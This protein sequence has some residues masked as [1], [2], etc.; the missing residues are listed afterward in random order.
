MLELFS[1]RIIAIVIVI[2]ISIFVII[3]VIAAFI[4]VIFTVYLSCAYGHFSCVTPLILKTTPCFYRKKLRHD[5]AKWMLRLS[6]P[7]SV[8]MGLGP[9]VSDIFWSH[10]H[11]PISFFFH[12]LILVAALIIQQSL[13][14]WK[15]SWFVFF[16]VSPMFSRS[17]NKKTQ[18]LSSRTWVFSPVSLSGIRRVTWWVLFQFPGNG[19]ITYPPCFLIGSMAEWE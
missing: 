18:A 15:F 3:I 14:W 4:A 17:L 7:I 19:V 1:S 12:W 10:F 11:S 8:E 5:K 2:I 16:I 13:K 9:H 6:L